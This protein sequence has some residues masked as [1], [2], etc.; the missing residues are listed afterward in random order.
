MQKVL[1]RTAHAHRYAKRRADQ[2]KEKEMIRD[3]AMA[4]Q[5]NTRVQ[6]ER[7][8]ASS[9]ERKQRRERWE[10]GALSPYA[11]QNKW[12]QFY[13]TWSWNQVQLPEVPEKLRVK[14][15]FVR[16]GDRVCIV[17]G[18]AHLKGKIGKVTG[19]NHES[20]TVTIDGL[21]MVCLCPSFPLRPTSAP[22]DHVPRAPS[23]AN[24]RRRW[25]SAHLHP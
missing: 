10:A 14:H 5:A 17:D 16:T 24:A 8:D 18:P 1:R 19:C 23:D 20:E 12:G 4:R 3:R 25:K 2:V 22:V 13:G 11:D 15:W 7:L 21:N 6:R 9:A